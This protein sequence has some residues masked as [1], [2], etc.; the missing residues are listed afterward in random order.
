[1]TE[2]DGKD[3]S[4]G[5]A[6]AALGGLSPQSVAADVFISYASQDRTAADSICG[7]LERQ[8][9]TCWIAPRDVV[10]GAFYADAIVRAIDA[11]KVVV[12]VLSQNA[13]GS[14]HVLREVER[15][16]S[17][18]HPVISLRIDVAPLP[19]AFEYF[20]N[21]SH[22]L[23]ASAMGVDRAL[24]KLVDA[25]QRTL[26][27]AAFGGSGPA[28]DLAR[29]SDDLSPRPPVGTPANQ[30]LSRRLVALAAAVAVILAYLIVDKVWLAKR[31]ASE[32]PVPAATPAV[33]PAAPAISEKSVAVLPFVDMSQK[34]DQEYFSDGLSEELIDLLT[35]IP[36]LHVPARTSSFYFKGQH[37]TVAEIA[38][39]LGVAYILE[40]SVRKAGSTVRVTV[41]LIR[42]DHGYHL[43][44]ETFDRD[45][46]D[47]F[48]VQD[49]IAARVVTALQATLPA[50]ETKSAGR[51]GNTE[52][53]EQYLLGKS[54][55]N[56]FTTSGFR[57]AVGA[58]GKAVAL[59]PYYA[60]AFARLAIAEGDLADR[61][62]EPPG[63]KRA[64][65]AA[66]RAIAIAP[67]SADGYMAR[68]YLRTFWV[69]DWDGAMADCDKALALDPNDPLTLETYSLLLMAEGQ[70]PA[71]TAAQKKLLEVD[72]L[73]AVAWAWLGNYLIDS[74]NL[75]QALGPLRRAIEIDPDLHY[76]HFFLAVDELLV[77]QPGQA[78]VTARRISEP[79]WRLAAIAAV[80]HSLGRTQDSQRAL[81]ELITTEAQHGAYQIA[82]VYAWRGEKDQAFAWLERAHE[83]RDGG[84]PYLKTDALLASLRDDPRYA[85]LLRKMKLPE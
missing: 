48:K 28:A 46:G 78:L 72:P 81:D 74:G 62:S 37:A 52:A 14:P 15:A 51:T 59:D 8:G 18:R 1:M 47:V 49:E 5:A 44:S 61:V 77:G 22:W 31:V 80:Q 50:M 41:Q 32:R 68:A 85:A 21:T 3:R 56:Q 73:A 71:A 36:E 45:V 63:L 25:V 34:K 26:T 29:T 66:E 23:D 60:A 38:K 83:Q 55:Y 76:A 4:I 64:I 30:R 16:A 58:F 11:V 13:A 69:W 17:K 57:R 70:L 79:T 40:G 12:L 35:K 9:V 19:A 7:A 75:S 6:P 24:P 33:A 20:L 10:P 54:F 67:N 42:A 2:S 65:A 27:S 84:L 82:E 39:A 43:W 53:H